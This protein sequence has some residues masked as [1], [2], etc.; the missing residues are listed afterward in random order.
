MRLSKSEENTLR[1]GRCWLYLDNNYNKTIGVEWIF[2]P[3]HIFNCS[4]NIDGV[5]HD[6]TFN[7]W[8]LFFK[9]YITFSGIFKWYP[10]EWNSYANEGKGGYLNCARRIGISQYGWF[11]TFYLWHDGEDSWY[12]DKCDKIFYKYFN[13]R[14]FIVGSHKY[15]TIE[16]DE[17]EQEVEMLENTYKVKVTYRYWH[18]KHKRW[19]FRFLNKKGKGFSF[20]ESEIRY[21]IKKLTDLDKKM[22]KENG[23]SY[24]DYERNMSRE[25]Y[26]LKKDQNINDAVRMYKDKVLKLRMLESKDW[27]PFD[28]RKN[29]YREQ[30]LKRVLNNEIQTI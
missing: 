3:F 26:I 7:F 13:M 21:P 5:E 22:I 15:H 2:K 9:F 8:F 14:D 19:I 6:Y 28:F 24:K 11:F 29:Y 20:D 10:K 17:F 30:K 16:E 25:H 1:K 4:L 23:W 12:P 27:V 18:L